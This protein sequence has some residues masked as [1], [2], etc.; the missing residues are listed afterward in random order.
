[1][2]DSEANKSSS[3]RMAVAAPDCTVTGRDANIQ[4]TRKNKLLQLDHYTDAHTL[5]N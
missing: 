4:N 1:M 2:A 3:G 5:G